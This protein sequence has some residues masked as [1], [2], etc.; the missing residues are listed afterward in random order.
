MRA[1][2]SRH[3]RSR[4]SRRRRKKE[5]R[6]LH[7][8][9]CVQKRVNSG[10]LR[11]ALV[12]GESENRLFS[13][14]CA[15][16]ASPDRTTENRGVPGSSP[17]LA[18]SKGLQHR[19]FA[20]G[21]RRTPVRLKPFR[22]P[23]SEGVDGTETG[24]AIPLM[25]R[26]AWPALMPSMPLR[27]PTTTRRHRTLSCRRARRWRGAPAPAASAASRAAIAD[28][29][30]PA[31]PVLRRQAGARRHHWRREHRHRAVDRGQGRRGRRRAQPP[32]EARLRAVLDALGPGPHRARVIPAILLCAFELRRIWMPPRPV[33][34]QLRLFD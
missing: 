22:G 12:S 16:P 25:R 14:D 6:R 31:L 30:P 15:P 11:E 7:L 27:R 4:R 24:C 34:V 19:G 2:S 10:L 1:A 8:L 3:L 5:M 28:H 29:A 13:R 20:G 32:A 21:A 18:I 9:N 23:F 33:Y 17:G 26:W